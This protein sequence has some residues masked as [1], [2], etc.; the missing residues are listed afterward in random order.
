[1]DAPPDPAT[2]RATARTRLSNLPVTDDHVVSRSYRIYVDETGLE[3]WQGH[4]LFGFAGVAGFGTEIL[5]AD[6]AWRRM[7][8]EHFGGEDIALHASRDVLMDTQHEA[9]SNF[10]RT[11]RL[12]RFSY[13]CE[14]PPLALPGIDALKAMRDFL[15][16]EV[17]DH[18]V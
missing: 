4:A 5:R 17:V 7:K 12:R 6:R 16:N 14:A 13:I 2:R 1:M 11:S 15:V 10:F 3:T 9:I 18:V 8:R